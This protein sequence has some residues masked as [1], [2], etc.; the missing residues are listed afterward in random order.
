MRNVSKIR[1]RVH[2]LKVEAQFYILSQASA[3]S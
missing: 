2:T 1:L 3:G